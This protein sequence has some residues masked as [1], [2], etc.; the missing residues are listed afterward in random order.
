M[1]AELDKK[2]MKVFIYKKAWDELIN[3]L[4]GIRVEK[5]GVAIGYRENENNIILGF[6]FFKQI[7]YSSVF[8]EFDPNDMLHALDI[9]ISL[10]EK[11]N[12]GRPIGIMAWVHTHPNLGIFL[13]GT[14]EVTL[15][16]FSSLD[17]NLVALVVDS[18]D[19][20]RVDYGAFRKHNNRSIRLECDFINDI[21]V[22]KFIIFWQEFKNQLKSRLKN[23]PPEF[24]SDLGITSEEEYPSLLVAEEEDKQFFEKLKIIHRTILKRRRKR[25]NLKKVKGNSYSISVFRG[26]TPIYLK[27]LL[28]GT[29]ETY[30]KTS[31]NETKIFELAIPSTDIALCGTNLPPLIREPLLKSSDGNLLGY[32]SGLRSALLFGEDEN[33]IFRLKGCGQDSLG[34]YIENGK[35][36][37][38]NSYYEIRGCQFQDS[39]LREQIITLILEEK[40]S[41][42]NILVGNKS[43]GW[44]VYHDV[45]PINA[46]CGLFL[47]EGDLRL[48]DDILFSLEK[49]LP[50]I[51]ENNYIYHLPE[52]IDFRRNRD[53]S[54]ILFNDNSFCD[55]RKYDFFNINVLTLLDK[56]RI[57][58]F[59]IN[60]FDFSPKTYEVNIAFIY[61]KLG[62]QMGYIKK[63]LEKEGFIWGTFLDPRESH[64]CNAHCNNFIL[65]ITG[66]N[67]LNLSIIDFDL[68][69]NKE[70][71]IQLEELK[72][73][74]NFENLL[75]IEKWFL[76]CDIVD[77]LFT[78]SQ[79]KSSAFLEE[80]YNSIRTCLRET[81]MAGFLSGYNNELPDLLSS[82]ELYFI[83]MSTYL[84]SYL[85]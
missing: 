23:F 46:Y 3:F 47:T 74:Y 21:K 85:S 22:D 37:S 50:F 65:N 63:V 29:K 44:W 24:I 35:Y 76:Q 19:K 41:K 28:L 72:N 40:L 75:R 62:S 39:C 81:M 42:H 84:E 61:W 73:N 15:S 31:K 70:S 30:I 11:Y 54:S 60:K 2:Q 4:H 77:A 64:H 59:P 8:C 12:L 34:I 83:L 48:K 27:D 9:L 53:M 49:L 79:D 25:V 1:K 56:I 80:P 33:T 58:E 7:H 57:K 43:L 5:G 10:N 38:G 55:A 18:Y 66:N 36:V 82:E 6:C 67:F 13:S 14:D 45:G 32:E 17:K 71:F 51:L 68:S 16:N 78:Q 69:F 52:E 20:T 26:N